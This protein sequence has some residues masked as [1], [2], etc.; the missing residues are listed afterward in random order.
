[1]KIVVAVKLISE[2]KNSSRKTNKLIVQ[3]T[4][5][6]CSVMEVILTDC[7]IKG[8]PYLCL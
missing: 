7:G 3:R 8:W 5:C 6:C 2:S 1:M 4:G